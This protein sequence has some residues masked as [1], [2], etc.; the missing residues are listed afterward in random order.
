[1]STTQSVQ[2]NQSSKAL[3]TEEYA[4]ALQII[5]TLR[6]SPQP[7]SRTTGRKTQSCSRCQ[8]FYWRNEV[9]CSQ[10]LWLNKRTCLHCL[11]KRCNPD[12]TTLEQLEKDFHYLYATPNHIQLIIAKH[13]E[14]LYNIY[15]DS[16]TPLK[17]I[18]SQ[19]KDETLYRYDITF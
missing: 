13:N 1:M 17:S 5:Q 4:D 16:K 7:D 15:H 12:S 19:P 8:K 14:V 2:I 11:V 10:D 6:D 9:I 3:T 18:P